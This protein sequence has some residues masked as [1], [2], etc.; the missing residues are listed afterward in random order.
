MVS[1]YAEYEGSCGDVRI[2]RG[3]G[4]RCG[5]GEKE[6]EEEKQEGREEGDGD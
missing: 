6:G 1:S 4:I 3:A 5:R 2:E